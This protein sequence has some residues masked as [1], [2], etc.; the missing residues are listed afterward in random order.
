MQSIKVVPVVIVL[1][2]TD[3]KTVNSNI[4][5]RVGN[6]LVASGTLGGRYNEQQAMREFRNGNPKLVIR[7]GMED[8][9]KVARLN[10]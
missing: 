9:A 6:N 10:V 5:V 7:A 8:V 2:K 3:K 4:L 1:H